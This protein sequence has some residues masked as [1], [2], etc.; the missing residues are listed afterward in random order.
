MWLLEH[1]SPRICDFWNVRQHLFVLTVIF[2]FDDH[3]YW[4][5]FNQL[6][7]V[8][9]EMEDFEMNAVQ[10]MVNKIRR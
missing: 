3:L 7:D 8:K 9:T 4:G 6:L 1:F 10:G 5:L 2:L